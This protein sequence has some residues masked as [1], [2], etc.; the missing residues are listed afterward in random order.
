MPA[1]VLRIGLAL[2]DAVLHEPAQP[3]GEY[4]LR[5]VEMDLEVVE[6]PHAKERVANDQQRPALPDRLERAGDRA[7]LALVVLAEH[8]AQYR[9]RFG[10]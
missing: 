1:G 10:H 6:A 2:E 5:D 7:I 4:G 3:V 8:A 9:D